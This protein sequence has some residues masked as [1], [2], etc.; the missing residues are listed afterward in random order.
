ME[1]NNTNIQSSNVFT[2]SKGKPEADSMIG[3]TLSFTLTFLG[4]DKY[5]AE[6]YVERFVKDVQ[7]LHT[8]G[9][10]EL[11]HTIVSR[12]EYKV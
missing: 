9:Y 11:K 3:V 2:L 4:N 1:S 7:S 8:Q 6:Q 12:Q 10:K 5:N